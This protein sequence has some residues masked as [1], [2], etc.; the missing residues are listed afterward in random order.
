MANDSLSHF[1]HPSHDN[2]SSKVNVSAMG[3]KLRMLNTY[4]HVFRRWLRDPSKCKFSS[5]DIE[6]VDELLE[7][8]ENI[9]DDAGR[10]L[11]SLD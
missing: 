8:L 2:F 3:S 7:L 9:V 4:L 10:I 6:M 11:P 1:A 5:E